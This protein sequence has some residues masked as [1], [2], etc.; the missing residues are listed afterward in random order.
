MAIIILASILSFIL[1]LGLFLIRKYEKNITKKSSKT[2]FLLLFWIVF[3][4]WLIYCYDYIVL[5]FLGFNTIAFFILN[6]LSKIGIMK[7]K[8]SGYF[9]SITT[10]YEILILIFNLIFSILISFILKGDL[11]IYPFVGTLVNSSIYGFIVIYSILI[12]GLCLY[13][14]QINSKNLIFE[15]NKNE[16]GDLHN[17][18]LML[19]MFIVIIYLLIWFPSFLLID[20]YLF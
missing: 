20:N 2:I 1:F 12:L 6:I 9:K 14:L 3:Y 11:W 15:I 5:I 19:R 17:Y 18:F 7:K 4:L 16:H 10:N 13:L 8:T